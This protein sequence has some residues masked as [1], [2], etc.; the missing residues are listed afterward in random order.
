MLNT[1]TPTHLQVAMPAL[2]IQQQTW[3]VTETLWSTKL[4]IFPIWRFTG[5]SL[6]I[7]ALL[8]EGEIWLLRKQ[9]SAPAIAVYM[10]NDPGLQYKDWGT[11]PASFGWCFCDGI[12]LPVD[13]LNMK[14]DGGAL[15][16]SSRFQPAQWLEWLIMIV[17]EEKGT[18]RWEEGRKIDNQ[19]KL[20]HVESSVLMAYFQLEKKMN[21]KRE[22]NF[23]SVEFPVMWVLSTEQCSPLF[24]YRIPGKTL[25]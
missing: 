22:V 8:R 11:F 20:G 4:K 14:N 19:Y 3:V 9:I 10:R 5:K 17:N 7:C 24:F 13:W 15:S 21:K 23:G 6:P 18:Y 2:S 12:K 16:V 1:T 25:L